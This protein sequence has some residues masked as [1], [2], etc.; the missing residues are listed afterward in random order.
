MK[1]ERDRLLIFI[2]TYNEADNVEAIYCEICK[3][4]L[5][6]DFLFL[7][8]NSPDGTGRIIDRMVSAS[9]RVHAIHRPGKEGIGAHRDGIQW[10]YD[11]GY[12]VLITMDCDF[13]HQPQ[14]IVQFLHHS[15]D[16]EVVIGSRFIEKNSLPNWN[17][18]RRAITYFG[19]FMTR[20]MLGMPL[21]ATGAFRA[22]RL[23]RIPPALF[24]L[25]QSRGYSFFFESLYICW[26]NGLNVKEIPVTL[27]ARTQGHSKM[28]IR[29]AVQSFK[30]LMA[31]RRRRS[32]HP[33]TLH[34]M[35]FERFNTAAKVAE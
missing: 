9:P 13:T 20:L 2:P 5:D 29:D 34:C 35:A 21:D 22:Y 4:Q 26:L 11:H 25:V 24:H 8:D 19:H 14:T 23:D 31:L 3:L 7:D 33:E 27:P 10:A 15:A 30:M 32:E 12:K 18:Q 6:A 28:A 1:A 16:H 17:L